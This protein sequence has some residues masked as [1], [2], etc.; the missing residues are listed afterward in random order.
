MQS[1]KE[2]SDIIIL[3]SHLGLNDDERI[4]SVFPEIHVI[5]G[6]HTH[7]VFLKGKTGGGQTLERAGKHGNFVG[8]V[9][10]P[11]R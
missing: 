11:G 6:A 5:L 1:L 2:E 8:Q 9:T 4:A 3:L 10:L 7:H